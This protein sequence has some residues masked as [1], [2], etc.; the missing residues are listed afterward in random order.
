MKTLTD[1]S[2]SAFDLD[3]DGV[4]LPTF[5]WTIADEAR[6]LKAAAKIA[7]DLI[8]KP[9]V[10]SASSFPVATE[11]QM[12]AASA[13]KY[14]SAFAWRSVENLCKDRRFADLVYVERLRWDATSQVFRVQ[15]R[16]SSED[17]AREICLRDGAYAVYGGNPARKK[18]WMLPFLRRT[19]SA[20]SA[21][22]VTDL[23]LLECRTPHQR[24]PPPPSS[25][26]SF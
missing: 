5:R 22:F 21:A 20:A 15:L 19:P 13:G 9:L 18:E 6:N 16:T 11:A 12:K 7:V 25:S 4:L 3:E 1:T 24:N 2:S 8:L 10:V 23:V 26:G 14:A 17:V